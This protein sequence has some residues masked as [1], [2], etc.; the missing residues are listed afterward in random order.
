MTILKYDNIEIEDINYSKP[1]KMGTS[2]FGSISFG[3]NI[4]T[5]IYSNP[6]LKCVVNM[7]ELKEEESIFG[8]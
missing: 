6:K 8:S 7:D 3:E 5:I 2:Y 4:T 1:E